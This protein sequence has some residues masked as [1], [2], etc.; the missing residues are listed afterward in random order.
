MIA[1]GMTALRATGSYLRVPWYLSCLA[2]AHAELRQLDEAW[3][4]LG[5]AM[6]VMETTKETWQAPDLHL[7]A[8]EF[9]LMAPTPAV[10][11]AEQHF[12]QALAVARA[13]RAKAWELRAA[14]SLARLWC[15][16]G[17]RERAHDVL[18]PVFGR[19]TEGFDLPD[20]TEAG[21]LLAELAG[22]GVRN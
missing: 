12:G 17:E 16:Q 13:Q 3:R 19:F 9:A 5:E 11:T 15:H 22:S 18:A 10:E 1:S 21:T 14:T 6:T 20:L 2:R 8:G 7:I 4:Y